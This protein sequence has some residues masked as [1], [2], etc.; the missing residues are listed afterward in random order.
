MPEHLLRS[1]I[2]QPTPICPRTSCHLV[3]PVLLPVGRSI[4]QLGAFYVS[5]ER[6]S[7][8]HN[9]SN[10][11][12]RSRQRFPSLSDAKSFQITV[13]PKPTFGSSIV[14]GKTLTL[15]WSTINGQKYRVQWKSNLSDPAWIDLGEVTASGSTAT[16]DDTVGDES[17]FYR[18]LVN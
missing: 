10:H 13:A 16:I 7:S 12:P 3:Y 8:R 18:I 14:A 17:R 2:L 9:D 6:R 11:C 5:D 4:A 15:A 1:P